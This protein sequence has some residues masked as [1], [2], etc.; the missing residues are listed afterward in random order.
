MVKIRDKS[1]DDVNQ[2]NNGKDIVGKVLKVVTHV[3]LYSVNQRY[4]FSIKH[5]VS[6]SFHSSS[7]LPLMYQSRGFAQSGQSL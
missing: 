5:A 2:T 6:G 4:N 7:Y 3:Y 1:V